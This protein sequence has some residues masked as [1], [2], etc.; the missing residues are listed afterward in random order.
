VIGEPFYL[1]DEDIMVT[2]VGTLIIG[3]VAGWI[4]EQKH[5]NQL[6]R[7]SRQVRMQMRARRRQGE[8]PFDIWK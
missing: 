1:D 3:A 6:L 7:W 4:F 5:G 8:S 2:F